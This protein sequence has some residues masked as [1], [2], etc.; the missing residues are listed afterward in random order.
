MSELLGRL[1][2][3]GRTARVARPRT[4]A[5]RLRLLWHDFVT[6]AL[7]NRGGERCQDCGRP[8]PLWWACDVLYEKIVGD[9]GGLF[10]PWCISQRAETAGLVLKWEP[11]EWTVA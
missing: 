4:V 9:L 5:G 10:C 7:L 2:W 3:A 8:Y 1:R 11:R 6:H